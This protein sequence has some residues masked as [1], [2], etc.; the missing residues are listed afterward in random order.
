MDTAI[1]AAKLSA[2]GGVALACLAVAWLGLQAG[3][4][5]EQ[6]SKDEQRIA[7]DLDTTVDT[8]NR[9]CPTPGH[10]DPCGTL[11]DVAKTLNTVRGTFG[12]IEVAANHEDANLSTLDSQEQHIFADLHKTLAASNETLTALAQTARGASVTL[13]AADSTI[14][15]FE[16]VE[17]GATASLNQFNRLIGDPAIPATI[18][19][20]EA[21]T[22]NASRITKDAA[23]EADKLA[24]PT[25]KVGF[26][27]AT[28]ATLLYIH[29][30]ILPPLF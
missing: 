4:A 25:K 11:A 2:F 14:A 18:A 26:W 24:H 8:L 30:H 3:A 13:N 10:I 9:P 21:I 1:K 6:A 29:S 22:A 12:Q 17:S 28:D 19:N 7:F 5:V 27:G 15:R 23:D 20:A 16:D